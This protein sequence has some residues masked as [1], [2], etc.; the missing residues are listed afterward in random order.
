MTEQCFDFL[1]TLFMD[2]FV[3]S[4][5]ACLEKVVLLVW[6]TEVAPNIVE[7]KFF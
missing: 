4:D 3:T 2:L 5:Y 7:V 1:N 6:A